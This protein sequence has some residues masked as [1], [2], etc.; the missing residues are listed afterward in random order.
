MP[1]HT[2]L[3]IGNSSFFR[4]LNRFLNCKILMIACK[5]LN[6]FR[7]VI[8]EADKVLD[9]IKK[10]FFLEYTLKK[11]VKL[12][13][14]CVFVVSVRCFPLHKSILSG[15]DCSGFRRKL[16]RHNEDSV[17]DKQRGNIVHIVAEL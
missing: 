12:S 13:I 9:N 5:Y 7:A 1:E 2:A 4:G 3:T 8:G 11:R 6:F 10:A 15:G 17:V 16:V 14:L